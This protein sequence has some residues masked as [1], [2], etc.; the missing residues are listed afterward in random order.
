MTFGTDNAQTAQF[1]YLG[2]FVC[3]CC[4]IVF[5]EFMEHLTGTVHFRILT[6]HIAGSEGNLFFGEALLQ[7]I[8]LRFEFRVAAQNNVGTTACHVG[9]DGYCTQTACFCNDGSFLVMLL[10]IQYVMLHTALLQHG[11]DFFGVFDGNGTNQNRLALFVCLRNTVCDSLELGSFRTKDFIFTVNSGNRTVGRNFHY[12]HVVDITEFIFFGLG[13]TGHTCQLVIH[14]E[15]ILQGNGS[16]GLGFGTYEYAFLGFD[17][18]V[19]AVAVTASVHETSGKFVNNDDFAVFHDVIHVALHSVSCLQCFLD[20]MVDFHVFR[21][22]QVIDREVSFRLV[23]TFFRQCHTFVFFFNGEVFFITQALYETVCNLIQ[24]CRLVPSAGNNQRRSGFV[25][26]NGVHFV[27]DG[28][29]QLSLQQFFLIGNHIISQ[30][31]ETEF[32]IRTVSNVCFIGSL[33]RIACHFMNHAANGKTQIGVDFAHPFCVSFCQI[34]VY[35]DN[36]YTLAFQRI[37][38]GRQSCNQSLTFPGL[39]FCDTSLMQGDTADNLYF[40][41][42]HAYTSPCRFTADCVSFHQ[43]VVQCFP[44]F[45]TCLEFRCFR[46]QFFVSQCCHLIFQCQDLVSHGGQLL[47]FFRVQIA[48]DFFK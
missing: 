41:V 6:V 43:Q 25:D 35:G 7:H 45:Q 24:V 30:V 8:L 9:C 40:E 31:V 14:S 39:H 29:V 37:Q 33:T 42:L 36:M 47:Y 32:V 23:N 46:L 21:I 20:V 13:C 48:K 34:V 11:A 17:G 44:V 19:E 15:V 16:Q 38:V 28:E 12:V 5:M 4:L 22:T 10:C 1:L 27:D 18:L 26:Q 2:L 3:T